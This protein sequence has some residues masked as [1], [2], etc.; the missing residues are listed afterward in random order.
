MLSKSRAAQS[1]AP[2]INHMSQPVI[3][4][5]DDRLPPSP[6]LEGDDSSGT[7]LNPSPSGNDSGSLDI[8]SRAN[9]KHDRIT[10]NFSNAILNID[11]SNIDR[12]WPEDY[13]SQLAEYLSKAQL[14]SENRNC[15]LS[16][17]LPSDELDI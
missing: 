15:P 8:P 16:E 12:L 1:N 2:L 4:K 7:E 17:I 14:K 3:I 9:P 5:K 10:V 13:D 11:Y 6:S